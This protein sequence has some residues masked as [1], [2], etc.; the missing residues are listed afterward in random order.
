M[1]WQTKGKQV[2]L[3]CGNDDRDPRA[4]LVADQIARD[5]GF[6]AL[7]QTIDADDGSDEPT[8]REVFFPHDTLDI[9]RFEIRSRPSTRKALDADGNYPRPGR[10]T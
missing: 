6:S 5:A 10:K 4:A 7:A 1:K 3:P 8:I 9:S 2:P